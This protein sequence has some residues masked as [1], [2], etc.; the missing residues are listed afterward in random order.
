MKEQKNIDRLFQE[1]FKDFEVFPPEFVWH[2][3]EKKLPTKKSKKKVVPLFW[4]FGGVAASLVFIGCLYFF[5][6][7]N[8]TS[9]HEENIVVS[10]NQLHEKKNKEN[11]DLP[12]YESP[13]ENVLNNLD[14]LS[15]VKKKSILDSKKSNQNRWVQNKDVIQKEF[16][17]NKRESSSFTNSSFQNQ[18]V[19]EKEQL[20]TVLMEKQESISQI[21]NR[22]INTGV[23]NTIV[24]G[25][26][27]RLAP[28]N[29][30]AA[31]NQNN[32]TLLA[33]SLSNSHA[34]VA[35]TVDPKNPL[36][37]L[38]LE[39]EKEQNTTLDSK[40]D[41][42]Q[43]ASS[44]APVYFNSLAG[45][46]SIDPQFA[47]NVKTSETQMS[48]GIGIQYAVNK[49]I[50]LRTGIN[51]LNLGYNTQGVDFKAALDGQVLSNMDPN[52]LGQ[53]FQIQNSS[54]VTAFIENPIQTLDQGFL[55]QRIGYLEV[56]FELKYRIIDQK[57]G[58]TVIGG[59][60]SLILTDNQIN[61]VT[62]SFNTNLGEATNLNSFSLSTNFGVGLDYRFF[63]SLQAHFEPMLKYQMNTFSNNT[64][65]FRPYFFGIYSGISYHF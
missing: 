35:K 28:L 62:A 33:D 55:N 53:T 42:W 19:H 4:K 20:E 34:A 47:E 40:I 11:F 27:N 16:S 63:K 12:K 51:M 57:F 38:L 36:E 49:K 37:E 58:F 50:S 24:E 65:G 3:I 21:N 25:D 18:M 9:K 31:L 1:K 17:N 7:N 59:M 30:H 48:Y 56:P 54:G 15:M 8:T 26:K 5:Y 6:E 45:G 60:S 22:P 29:D 43:I 32:K 13:A 46:S 61:A 44:I 14:S 39:K 10:P 64:S 52:A 2:Q 23:T 41:R